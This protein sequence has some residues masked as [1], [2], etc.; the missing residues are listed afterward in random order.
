VVGT[1][2]ITDCRDSAAEFLPRVEP[3]DALAEVASWDRVALVCSRP[4]D[5]SGHSYDSLSAK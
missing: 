5:G 4:A 1:V 2:R 3:M